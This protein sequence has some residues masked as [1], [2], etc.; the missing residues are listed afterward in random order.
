MTG[1]EKSGPNLDSVGDKFSR[2]KLI[3]QI[4]L[5]SEAIERGFERFA[6][7]M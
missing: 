1:M 7:V 3:R 4:V 6:L 2:K 5:P